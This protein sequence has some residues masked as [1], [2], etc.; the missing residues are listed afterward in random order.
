MLKKIIS[1]RFLVQQRIDNWQ[2]RAYARRVSN[3]GLTRRLKMFSDNFIEHDREF[4]ETEPE[5]D[6]MN[7]GKAHKQFEQE[8]KQYKQKISTMIVGQKYFKERS[9]NFL[10][11]SEKEQIRALNQ[12]HPEEWPIDRLSESFPADPFTIS[13]IIR[14]PWQPRDEKRV[15]KH[16]ESV[17]KSWKMFK[18]GELDDEVEPLLAEHLKKFAHRDF[19][20]TVKPKGNRKFGVEMPKPS[21]DEFSSIITSCKKYASKEEPEPE[22]EN[23]GLQLKG[24]RLRFPDHYNPELDSVVLEGSV[25]KPDNRRLTLEQYQRD[26]NE[27]VEA[28]PDQ[29]RVLVTSKPLSDDFKNIQKYEKVDASVESLKF[30]NEKVFKSLEIQEEI[31]IPKKLWQEGQIYKYGDCFYSDD[32]EFLY[33]VPGLK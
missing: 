7:V 22:P 17:R 27:A 29:E 33:R 19:N 28:K 23:N 9:I 12:E 1:Y 4:L 24:S 11:W 10:T 30:S 5:S 15:Q 31:K 21:R 6:F 3:P 8:E 2:F 14:N 20:S 13:K 16:D 18:A 32:G 26:H 25:G